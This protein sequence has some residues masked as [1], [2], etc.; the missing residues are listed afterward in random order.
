MMNQQGQSRMP[1]L[2]FVFMEKWCAGTMVAATFRLRPNLNSNHDGNCVKG[3]GTTMEERKHRLRP[4]LY[5]GRIAVSFT[6]CTKNRVQ[7]FS[8]EVVTA[9][10][11]AILVSEATRAECSVIQAVFMPDHCHIILMGETEDADVLRS[12]KAFKQK[13]GHWLSKNRPDAKWQK[14]F[15]DH[16]LRS[17]EDMQKHVLYMLENPFRK[18]IVEDWEEYK[19]RFSS[20]F[21]KPANNGCRNV[22]V[23]YKAPACT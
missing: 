11:A 3:P 16:I 19:F 17:D 4:E 22:Q 6:A 18:G 9:S 7:V 1:G 5:Q 12:M 8:D 13:S 2:P 15:Y 14:D 21:K 10:I 20:E 23:A